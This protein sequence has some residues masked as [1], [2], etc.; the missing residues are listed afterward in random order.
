M[1]L[2]VNVV[3]RYSGQTI[4]CM[5][6]NAMLYVRNVVSIN[7]QHKVVCTQCM[8]FVLNV[9]RNHGK[10][11]QNCKVK[12]IRPSLVRGWPVRRFLANCLLKSMIIH[13]A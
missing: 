5:P 12:L 7:A 11:L 10:Y 6:Y 9:P 3:L 2:V 8:S 13:G 1:L 4:W